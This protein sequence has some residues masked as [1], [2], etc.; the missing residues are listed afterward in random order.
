MNE[1]LNLHDEIVSIFEEMDAEMKTYIKAQSYP[2]MTPVIFDNLL[3][4]GINI[5]SEKIKTFGLQET[6]ALIGILYNEVPLA[7]FILA[8]H[9]EKEWMEIIEATIDTLRRTLFHSIAN[10]LTLNYRAD[11]LRKK[12]KE[13]V[14]FI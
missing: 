14:K 9:V 7:L 11:Q 8:P 12:L 4:K 13:K 6:D 2:G 3:K 10:F 5:Y 1:N